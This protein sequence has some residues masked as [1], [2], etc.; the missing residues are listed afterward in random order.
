MKDF[1]HWGI[2]S[3]K[4]Q[5]LNY[6]S[7]WYNLQTIRFGFGS[8]LPLPPDKAEF[9]DISLGTKCNVGCEFCYAKASKDGKNF[10]N[11]C[12]KIKDFF[13][14]T[15][16]G[17]RPYQIAIGV[18]KNKSNYSNIFIV[19]FNKKLS[20]K[21]TKMTNKSIPITEEQRLK[22]I[23]IS[24]KRCGKAVLVYDMF[25]NFVERFESVSKAAKKY[26]VIKR[27]II[28]ACKYRKATCKDHIFRYENSLDPGEDYWLNRYIRN[29]TK[30]PFYFELLS[31]AGKIVNL[32]YVSEVE[33]FLGCCKKIKS[34]VIC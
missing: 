10:S 1:K 31:P 15:K 19:V 28:D 9:Y 18:I 33:E 25:G 29:K 20:F 7:L 34:Y 8:T 27:D 22:L 16:L 11:V 12:E 26:K 21:S 17:D 13:K 32:K 24:T 3:K 5:D 23:D 4:Y 6:Q 14:N 30:S 2:K